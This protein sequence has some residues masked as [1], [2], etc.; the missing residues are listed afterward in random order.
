M[1]LHGGISFKV[2]DGWDMH[3]TMCGSLAPKSDLET[4]PGGRQFRP[5]T[6]FSA[7]FLICLFRKL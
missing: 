7:F 2:F 4:R 5:F 3:P 1:N 6:S